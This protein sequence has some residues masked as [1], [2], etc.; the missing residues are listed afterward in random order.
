MKIYE[1]TFEYRRDFHAIMVCE[2]CDHTQELKTGYDDDY[3]H[4]RVIPAMTCDKCGKNRKGE[5]V[6]EN[7]NGTRSV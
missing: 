4:N 5:I 1:T 6:R 3:Y 2:H 7:K